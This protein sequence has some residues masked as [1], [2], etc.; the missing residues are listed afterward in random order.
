M[1]GHDGF[2]H[3]PPVPLDA[4]VLPRPPNSSKRWQSFEYLCDDS[5]S[6]GRMRGEQ[7]MAWG[8][9]CAVEETLSFPSCWRIMECYSL[10]LEQVRIF[11]ILP[12][13]SFFERWV[14]WQ[15]C[16]MTS[17]RKILSKGTSPVSGKPSEI[18]L[19]I[20]P[21][22]NG[23][24]YDM[25]FLN[26]FSYATLCLP[27]QPG[28]LAL[29]EDLWVVIHDFCRFASTILYWNLNRGQ[30]GSLDHPKK[31]VAGNGLGDQVQI[32]GGKN[33]FCRNEG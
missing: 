13:S 17:P 30:L 29:N 16:D 20:S 10:S 26:Q 18:L 12:R 15:W 23:F 31:K 2:L 32:S 22:M 25:F 6:F 1:T 24:T 21:R 11:L 19:S 28:N 5:W 4:S 33:F 27:P 9:S 3:L 8:R 14:N 7:L